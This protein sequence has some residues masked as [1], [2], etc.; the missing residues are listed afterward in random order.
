MINLEEFHKVNTIE[1]IS[2]VVVREPTKERSLA[3]LSPEIAKE[4]HPTLNGSLTPD[5][6]FNGSSDKAW[7]QCQKVK[8]HIWKGQI[9]LRTRKD[10]KRSKGC[11]IC[12][13]T[14]KF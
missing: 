12:N 10:K 13:R 6:V 3:F 1:A 5:D 9:K 8:D 2:I 4:W 14:N 11:R 7:W